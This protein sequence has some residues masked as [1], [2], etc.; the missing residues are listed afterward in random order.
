MSRSYKHRH[1][2][3]I[4]F[5]ESDTEGQYY[6]G[7]YSSVHCSYDK[8]QISYIDYLKKKRVEVR[9]GKTWYA[10]HNPP[11]YFVEFYHRS[12]RRLCKQCLSK[13]DLYDCEEWDVPKFFGSDS[14]IWDWN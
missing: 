11:R 9:Q 6:K 12:E 14:A 4:L 3:W 13:V 10:R 1:D 5:K 2:S 7:R 8:Y